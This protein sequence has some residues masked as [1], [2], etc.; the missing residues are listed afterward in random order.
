MAQPCFPT[1]GHKASTCLPRPQLQGVQLGDLWDR[2]RVLL[3]GALPAH[4]SLPRLA[5][6]RRVLSSLDA[7]HREPGEES[8]E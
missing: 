6:R 5:L 2:E 1:L 3:R 8:P 4:A 7:G